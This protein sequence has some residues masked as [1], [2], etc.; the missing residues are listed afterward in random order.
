VHPHVL[1][2]LGLLDAD[3]ALLITLL[4]LMITNY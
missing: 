3:L 2:A 1:W 4:A